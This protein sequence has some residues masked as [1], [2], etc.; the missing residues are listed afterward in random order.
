MKGLGLQGCASGCLRSAAHV[1]LDALRPAFAHIPVCAQPR[2]RASSP[3]RAQ[4]QEA[5]EPEQEHP[6][7]IF[8]TY[9]QSAETVTILDARRVPPAERQ[10]AKA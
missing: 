1:K 7:G 6:R 5:S 9:P 10:V 4:T 3:V 8:E 2:C